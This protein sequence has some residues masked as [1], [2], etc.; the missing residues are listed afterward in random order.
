MSHFGCTDPDPWDEPVVYVYRTDVRVPEC[1]KEARAIER[2]RGLLDR[3][4][5][6]SGDHDSGGMV[7]VAPPSLARSERDVLASWPQRY[8]LTL[9]L[10]Y[11]VQSLGERHFTT[12]TAAVRSVEAHHDL[13][14]WV[15]NAALRVP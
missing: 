14:S 9:P 1:A 3:C 8:L 7:E 13:A 2:E 12:K 11:S 6:R 10:Q 15:R 4:A 5:K